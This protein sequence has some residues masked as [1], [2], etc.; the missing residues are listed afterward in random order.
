MT[1]AEFRRWLTETLAE[2]EPQVGDRTPIA[3][4][5]EI[6]ATAKHHAYDVGLHDLALSLPDSEKVK[7]PLTAA[8]QLRR[9]L[10]AIEMPPADRDTLTPP[11]IA[12]RLKKSPDTVL[13]WIRSGQLKAS[14]LSNGRKARWVITPSDLQ[15]FLKS[16]QPDKAAPRQRRSKIS[17]PGGY[18][19]FST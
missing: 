9:C 15:A 1:L 17:I 4:C 6:V 10:Q 19:R 16:K 14:N 2:L 3:R 7:T 5:A 8:N 18:R 11:E 12:K 13:A